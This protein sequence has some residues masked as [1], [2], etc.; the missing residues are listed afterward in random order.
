VPI[1]FQDAE[2]VEA[3]GAAGFLKIEPSGTGAGYRGALFVMNVRGE[4]LEFAYNQ[5]ETPDTFL[6]R[7]LDLRR[8]AERKLTASLFTICG[9]VPRLI[10]CLAG[11]VGSELFC[12]DLR[13]SVP[14][15]RLGRP[16]EAVSYSA[17]ET[18]E[19]VEQPEPLEPLHVFWCTEP[20]APGTVERRLLDHLS[21][22]GLLLE[23]FERAATG[24]QEVYGEQPA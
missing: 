10:L 21:V 12:Q 22:H 2:D 6:W 24:L 5:V 20:P 11:E 16:L 17:G 23:P 18:E 3:L 1:P 14:V 13:V 8:H 9:R 19:E 7:P 15:G 4:P